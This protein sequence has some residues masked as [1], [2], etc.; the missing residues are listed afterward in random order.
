[1]LVGVPL[2]V[3]L[4]LSGTAV[5]ALHGTGMMALPNSVWTGIAKYPL[6]AIPVF[7]MAGMIFERSGVAIR[8]VRFA[9]ALIGE[10]HGG[11]GAVACVVCMILG[12]IS[13]SGPADAAAVASVMIPAMHKAGYPKPYSAALI[14]AA[15]STAIL[16]PPSIGFILY[17]VLVPQVSVPAIFAAGLVPG[18]LA[19]LALTLPNWW[20]ARRHGMGLA[21]AAIGPRP[22]LWQSFK[23]AGWGLMAPVLILG[24]MRAGLFTPTEAAV[25]AVF[26]GLFVGFVVYRTLTLGAMWQALA[27]A[28][29]I[30]GTVLLVIGLASVFAHAGSTL[31]TFD[32]LAQA[33][34]R[35][36]MGEV[37]V[38]LAINLVLLV[39]GM[40]LDAV[41][42]LFIFLPILVPVAR[43]FG[44][45]MTWF[46]V[47]FMMNMA[48]GQFT[49]PV[50][51]NLLVTCRIA[52]IPVES[53][54]RWVLWFV[55]AMGIALLLVAFVP[56]MALGLPRILGYLR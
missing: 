42:V 13:G 39:A 19:G 35:Q 6:L 18:L 41:S 11:L 56:E 37:P 4:G 29:E 23:E 48:I 10:R 9:S 14:A 50:A 17:T 28:A 47:M 12:G 45:D 38:L 15:G 32:H 49:P 44:W 1:M 33:V 34:L 7:I 2:G 52:G 22:P 5:L 53:T 3:A 40:F 26:Y 20:L 25:V 30:A 46:G 55:G 43:N 31:G 21:D 24:G 51:V 36:G 54:V 16:I 8:L 27:D